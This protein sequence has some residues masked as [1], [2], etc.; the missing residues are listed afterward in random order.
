M[1]GSYVIKW[2]YFSYII[3]EAHQLFD[4]VNIFDN[5]EIMFIE[6]CWH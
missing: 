4:N 5:V 3:L 6:V 2:S 1:Y